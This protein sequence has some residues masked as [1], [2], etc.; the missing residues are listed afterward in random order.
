MLGL[1]ILMVV[2]GVFILQMFHKYFVVSTL[3]KL[4]WVSF[5]ILCFTETFIYFIINGNVII[6]NLKL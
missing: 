5:W 6:N 3:N 4:E 1:I 2:I